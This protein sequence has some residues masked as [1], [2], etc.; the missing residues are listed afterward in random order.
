M[1]HITKKIMTSSAKKRLLFPQSWSWSMRQ[2][3]AGYLLVMEA[4]Q[5]IR[6]CLTEK[7]QV[8]PGHEVGQN[9]FQ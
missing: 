2:S 4:F 8:D 1:F 5:T 9:W 6:E 7:Q 3:L